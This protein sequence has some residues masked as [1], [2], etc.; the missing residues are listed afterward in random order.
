MSIL[1]VVREALESLMANKMRSMLTVL[2]IVIGVASVIAMMAIG[3]GVQASITGQISDIGTNLI[4]VMSGNETEEL[5][6]P[7]P[8]TMG[9]AEAMADPL[10]AP[11]V[12]L[13]APILQSSMEVST[14]L[15]SKR[16]TI[17]GVTVSYAEVSNENLTEGEFFTDDHIVAK[18]AVAVIGPDTAENLLGRSVG[19]TGETVRIDGTPFR[20]IGVLEAKGGSGFGSQDDRILVPLTTAQVRLMHRGVRDSVDMIEAQALDADSV[21]PATEEIS[22]ILRTRHRTEVGVDDFTI[23]T[24]DSILDVATSV[25]GV[26]TLFLG[27]V[28]AISLLV[29]GIGIMNI[30]LV[31]VTERTKE[32]GLRKAIGAKKRDILIQFLTESV[33]LSLLGGFVGII[34]AWV[35]ATIVGMIF[36]ASG[37]VIEPKITLSAVLLATMVSSAV[38]LIF[39]IFPANNAAKLQPVEALRHE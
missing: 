1:Q 26:I 23:F 11:S 8:L 7:K 22:E 31:S 34:L 14:A 24:Q 15:D 25:T 27:G 20:I 3:E 35:L 13:V 33:L 16:V 12:A 10:A 29:G 2:G 37:T 36:A 19:V 4:F 21:V 5:R 17:S 18:S 32:I 28:A 38:G 39:G 6:N 30:M 9:D